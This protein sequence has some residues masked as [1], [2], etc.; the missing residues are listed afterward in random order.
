MTT[1]F[2]SIDANEF[3]QAHPEFLKILGKID[4]LDLQI[5]TDL[6]SLKDSVHLE[7]AKTFKTKENFKGY[8]LNNLK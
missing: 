2:S 1:L 5:K 7:I 4:K 6:I 8:N 3:N